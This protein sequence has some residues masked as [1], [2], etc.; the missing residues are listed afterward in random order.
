MTEEKKSTHKVEVL[1]I[2]VE[3]IPG[4]DFVGLARVFGY[5]C[6][7]N[8]AQWAGTNML[9][10]Y[11]PPD[12][13]VD[14]SR[15][16]FSF[17]AK[18]AKAD[19]MARI[20]AKRLRGVLSFGLL[21]P[22]P[23]GSKEGDDVAA[24]LGVGH[25]DPAVRQAQGKSGLMFGGEAASAPDVYCVKYDLEAGRRY[26]QQAFEPGEPVVVSEKLHGA[27]ARYVYSCGKMHCG[28]RTEWKKE[29]PSYE[30]LSEEG[31]VHELL[32]ANRARAGKTGHEPL[33]DEQALSRAREILEKLRG[34]PKRQNLW[35]QALDATPSLRAFCEKN[36]DV[37]VYGEVYGAVQDLNYGCKNGEVRFAAFDMM[38]DGRFVDPWDFFDLCVGYDV[39]HVP[40]LNEHHK[41]SEWGQLPGLSVKPIPF[42]FDEICQIAEGKSLVPGASHVREGVVVSPVK[43]RWDE[44]LGRVKLKF[45]GCGYLERSREPAEAVNE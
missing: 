4:S 41:T 29:Y 8:K 39:P 17:L 10:A 40:L 3:D 9:A 31:I 14:V 28:S 12:S 19:G 42:D 25:Y 23:E 13:L 30:H 32:V 43:E 27:N 33:D 5:T 26:A 34:Q 24:L 35:W 11:L 16:E 37:V 1:R 44:R 38:R 36:P 45:V 18:D 2:S 21:V 7:T 15:P 20:K 22:A 6:V